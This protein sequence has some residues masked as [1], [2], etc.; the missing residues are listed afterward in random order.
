MPEQTF[1]CGEQ[2]PTPGSQFE[3]L[4][5]E[6]SLIKKLALTVFPNSIETKEDIEQLVSC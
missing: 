1:S 3:E 5:K 2:F 6:A 4:V